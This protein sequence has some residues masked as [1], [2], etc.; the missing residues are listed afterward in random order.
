MATPSSINGK[1]PDTK[2]PKDIVRMPDEVTRDEWILWPRRGEAAKLWGIPE[3]Q[4]TGRCRTK[5]IPIYLADDTSLRV[6]PADLEREFGAQGS[7]EAAGRLGTAGKP[8]R[9]RTD[10][11][12]I[13]IDDPYPGLLTELRGVIAE[14]MDNQRKILDLV[15]KPSQEHVT[16][17][18]ADNA[19]KTKR[20]TELEERWKQDQDRRLEEQQMERLFQLETAREKHAE[21][22]R[23]EIM[24]MLSDM[25]PQLVAKWRGG[26]T[27]IEFLRDIPEDSIEMMLLTD[28][29]TDEKKQQ[30]RAAVQQ[31]QALRKVTAQATKPSAPSAPTNG[32]AKGAS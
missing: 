16:A 31:L 7:A 23:A 29:L 19:G 18:L 20:I 21:D 13:D 26:P 2:L 24:K 3:R 32:A 11:G 1:R 22:R 9:K 14:L 28:F 12:E 25:V 10:D 30:V 27:V 5:A 17:L 15:L 4:L 8:G 6:D